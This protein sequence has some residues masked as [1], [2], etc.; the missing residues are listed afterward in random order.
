MGRGIPGGVQGA[1]E[2]QGACDWEKDL[3]TQILRD[4]EWGHAFPG[5]FRGEKEPKGDGKG[6]IPRDVRWDTDPQGPAVRGGVPVC[7]AMG[8]GPSGAA[9]PGTAL[10]PVPRAARVSHGNRTSP[11]LL[12]PPLP[13]GRETNAAARCTGTQQRGSAPQDRGVPG[14]GSAF[15]PRAPRPRYSPSERGRLGATPAA[16]A[17]GA[18]GAARGP[19]AGPVPPGRSER[20]CGAPPRPPPELPAATA[21]GAERRDRGR[22]RDVGKARH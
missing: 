16:A 15:A 8:Q 20:G 6:M 17:P 5:E 7:P 18:A 10:P 9:V 2:A 4:T 19:R 14:V 12:P 3:G 22:G 21:T 13:R 1:E 11:A